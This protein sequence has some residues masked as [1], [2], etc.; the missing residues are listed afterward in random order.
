MSL[1]E[2]REEM[3]DEAWAGGQGGVGDYLALLKPR[4]M[5]LVI[6]TAL[7][8]I[9]IAPGGIH[10]VLGFTALLCI[11]IGA[12][13]SGALNMWYDADIDRV[14]SRTRNRPI[15][16][17]KVT[18]SEA[19]A[20]G[21]TL[22]V[23]SVLVLGL[24]VNWLSAGLLAFTIFFYVVIYTMWLKRSTPQNIVIGGAAGAFPPMVGWAAVTGSVSLES[25]VLFLII[26]MWTPPH[27]WALALFKSSDYE[28]AGVPMMP[29]VAGD[30]ST[31]NQILLY[32]LILA[33]V[34]VLPYALGFGGLVYGVT[35]GVLGAAFLLLAYRVWRN[36]E[37]DEARRSAIRLFSFSILYL[38]LLFAVLLGEHLAVSLL[39]GVA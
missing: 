5:S 7:V 33:P 28:A 37:G 18:R 13:A 34:G 14:M 21:M 11:A 29:V 9:A 27:F 30:A 17:G 15:P 3:V 10:P 35:S 8:G 36:R 32:S 6:F 38:F 26:F 16:A 31:R 25:I 1:A 39:T 22:A 4:V 12:G 23:L 19:L 20:F 24:L 2:V